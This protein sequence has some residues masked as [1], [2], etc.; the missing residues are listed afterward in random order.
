MARVLVAGQETLIE[1]ECRVLLEAKGYKLLPCAKLREAVSL[2][3]DDPPDLVIAERNFDNGHDIDLFDS[4]K[5]CLHKENIPILLIIKESMPVL[6]NWDLFPVDDFIVDPFSPEMLLARIQLA[7]ARIIRV[8]DNNPLSKLPGNTSII[9]AIQQTI[10]SGDAYG[11]CHLDI[12]NFKPYNDRYGFSQGDEVL[13]MVSRLI[14]NVIEE[15]A[16]EDSFV[17]HVGGDDFVFIVKKDNIK[18]VC[19]KILANFEVVK[20]MFIKQQ[21]LEA[22]GYTEK[23]RQGRET[24]YNLLSISISVIPV[25]LNKFSHYGEVSAVA[26]QIKHCL[27]EMEGSNYMIDKR[28]SYTP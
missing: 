19:D 7:E 10:E 17:G 3:L 20:N 15:M 14:A 27:K 25:V 24:H 5:S 22:G 9:K 23:D 26:S 12:D 11:V 6:V 18:P 16:R 1:K 4:I 8:F 21:D 2:V 13:L 28:E